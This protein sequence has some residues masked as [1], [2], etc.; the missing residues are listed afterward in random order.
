[1]TPLLI[2]PISSPAKCPDPSETGSPEAPSVAESG[3]SSTESPLTLQ[4]ELQIFTSTLLTVFLAEIGDK[5][6]V[7][8]LLMSAGSQS[9][10]VVF[11][12]AGSAL[13]ATTLMGVLLGRWLATYVS[14]KT[15]EMSAAGLLLLITV[16]LLR[17]VLQG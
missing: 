1:M 10:W 8:V 13:V 12:G 9:P 4:Q 2:P 5:T 6:Q 15:L 14:Q 16:M 3:Q 11:L 7:T 17:D